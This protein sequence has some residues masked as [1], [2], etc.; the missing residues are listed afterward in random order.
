MLP[1]ALLLIEL[2]LLEDLRVLVPIQSLQVDIVA[3]IL[4]IILLAVFKRPFA[5]LAGS[6]QTFAAPF[7]RRPVA[8]LVFVFVL[9]VLV[10][11]ALLPW[12]PVPYPSVHDECSYLLSG[13]TFASGRLTNATPASA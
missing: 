11:V 6:I 12:V 9:A 10:R 5:T 13:D 4:L 1:A 7:A 3:A 8:P 2:P